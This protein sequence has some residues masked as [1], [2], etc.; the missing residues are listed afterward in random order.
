MM[1][2]VENLFKGYENTRLIRYDE[3]SSDFPGTVPFDELS[4]RYVPGVLKANRYVDGRLTQTYSTQ[5]SHVA[6]IAATRL[7]KTTE[8]VI[9]TIVSYAKQK[10]KRSMVISDPKGELYRTT[11]ET[12]RKEGYRVKLFN[13]RDYTH[14]E[15]WNP[16]THIYRAYQKAYKIE[17][18]VEVVQ[19][20]NGYRNRFMDKIYESQQELDKAVE[21]MKRISMEN[22]GNEI[23]KL[24]LMTIPTNSEKDPYWEDSA[25]VLLT[26]LIWAMLEDSHATD[27]KKRI[28]EDNFSFST[29][30][31]IM[32]SMHDDTG[33]SY[34]DNGYF[35]NRDHSCRSYILAKNCILENASAT[36]KCIVSS[37]NSK[38]S[39]Y[40]NSMIRLITSCNS[41]H[42]DELLEDDRPIAIYVAYRD[43]VKGHYQVISSLIQNAYNC[44]I[45]YATAQP[46]GKLKN[47]FMFILDEFGNFPAI[48]DFETVISACAGRNIWFILILQSYAQL[49][50]VYG[51]DVSEII[52]DN[53]NVHVFIGSNNFATLD[54]FCKECGETTRLSPLSA[55]NGGDEKME[56]FA[57]ETLPVMPKSSL[58]NLDVG[59]CIVT[60]ANCGYVL[61]SRMERYYLCD[62][63]AYLPK[64]MESDYVNDINPLESKY[65][66]D[67]SSP[68]TDDDDDDDD[69]LF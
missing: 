17:E 2:L 12:L 47:P 29:A 68:S 34:N 45:E 67:T 48:K 42:M 50:K 61:Y 39:I 40:K 62:E 66:Y 52:R 32:D 57:M 19:T 22:V 59:D 53:L 60:E 36:R 64:A 5:D 11:S 49:N 16:L 14:S 31:S 18:E 27:K 6:V 46:N 37:F 51:N 10:V 69:D 20:E 63:F 33:S 23:D 54:A 9:P 25:R 38:M 55:L 1:K 30:L 28:T 56:S 7:G 24:A 26:A 58:S 4:D 35:S 3:M 13:F 15:Y 43:E 8:Y 65:T 44:L 21:Q 41:F